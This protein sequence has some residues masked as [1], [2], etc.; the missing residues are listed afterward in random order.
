MMR[1]AVPLAI[2]A[3]LLSACGALGGPRTPFATY[4]P[5]I[6]A[7][8]A[9]TEAPARW[10]LLV[11]TP[12]ASDALDSPRIAVMPRPGV[13]EV[14]PAARWSDSTPHMLRSLVV[15]AFDD[16]RRISGTSGATT[17]LN[18]DFSLAL[19]LRDFQV[20]I[21][22][23]GAHAAI[24][25]NAKLVD[26]TSNRILATQAFAASADVAAAEDVGSAAA[27]FGAALDELL[28][29]LVDWTVRTGNAFPREQAQP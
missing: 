18:A 1:P 12:R 3:V 23:S 13:L 25:F 7:I 19:D 2:A 15:R 17:G 21:D 11:D 10:Q 27:A 4:A 6:T 16:S 14:Y 8:P 28:P 9:S 26:R 22:G 20:E 5:R 29:Q 24:R